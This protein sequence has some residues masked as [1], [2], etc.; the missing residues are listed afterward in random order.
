MKNKIMHPFLLFF[1][2]FC[3]IF[4]AIPSLLYFIWNVGVLALYTAGITLLLCR[5]GYHSIKIWF[6]K[7][8]WIFRFVL[9]ILTLAFVFFCYA[10][11][12]LWIYGYQ[13]QPT[14]ANAG[15]T[16]IVLG[17]QIIGDQPSLSLRKRLDKAA[18]FLISHPDANCIVT[19]GIGEG[20]QY[21]EAEI[22]KRYL[23]EHGI[24]ADR[25]YPEEQSTGTRENLQYAMQIA[26]EHHL[27]LDFII[28]SDNYHQYRAAVYLNRDFGKTATH[29]SSNGPWG[30]VPCYWVR[31]VLGVLYLF[32][33][34]M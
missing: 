2:I 8:K 18:A 30:I 10:N 20:K 4:A 21:S 29:L 15:D 28:I 9:G 12:I 23:T 24:H 27:P 26:K 33:E 5:K 3:L 17:C 11:T 6:G 19:G 7:H 34:G 1:G 22:M 13:K 31:E 25:I 32:V 16:V 14:D